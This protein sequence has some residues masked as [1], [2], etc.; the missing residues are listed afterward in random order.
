MG[1]RIIGKR[2]LQGAILSVVIIL[3]MVTL[4]IGKDGDGEVNLINEVGLT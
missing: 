2:W 3:M 1:Y 4:E